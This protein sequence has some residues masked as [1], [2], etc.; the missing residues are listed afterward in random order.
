MIGRLGR[1]GE[2][3]G[4]ALVLGLAAALWL[5][6]A[7]SGAAPPGAAPAAKPATRTPRPTSPTPTPPPT[8][9]AT[10][11]ATAT[12][13]PTPSWPGPIRHIV[14]MDKENRTF[15]DYFGT[16]PGAD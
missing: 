9:T 16:F 2:I 8:A 5:V 12:A 4:L 15:D 13:T 7:G 14:I 1:F 3:R 6:P 10:V 11:T